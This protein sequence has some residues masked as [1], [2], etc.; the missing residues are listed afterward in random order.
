M[1]MFEEMQQDKNLIIGEISE[2]VQFSNLKT[3]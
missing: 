2:R 3:F 1:H